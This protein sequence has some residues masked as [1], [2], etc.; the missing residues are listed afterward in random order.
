MNRWPY[1][2]KTKDH[3]KNQSN[4]LTAYDGKRI[5]LDQGPGLS[6]APSQSRS[7]A[8]TGSDKL[9]KLRTCMKHMIEKIGENSDISPEIQ[10]L[11]EDDPREKLNEQQR[12]MNLQRKMIN[13]VDKLKRQLEEK[14]T[15]FQAWKKNVKETLKKEEARH[16][17]SMEKLKK[18]LEA[19]IAEKDGVI[20]IHGDSDSD[21]DDSSKSEPP[22]PQL[23]SFMKHMQQNMEH[24]MAKTQVLEQQNQALMTQMIQMQQH[25]LPFSIG[26]MIPNAGPESGNLKDSPQHPSTP[27]V[28][29]IGDK[30][31]P[32]MIP[33]R[34]TR[35]K[36]RSS[37]YGPNGGNG[38]G[39]TTT[40][41]AEVTTMP[42]EMTT[43]PE[44]TNE[45]LEDM[46]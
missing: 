5:L 19:C 35:P 17:E 33:F 34:N 15:K 16:L 9:D 30:V 10:E 11:L 44:E 25:F 43:L 1:K 2:Q 37:P 13:K 39:G 45:K 31:E 24:S 29:R 38:P 41:V 23:E 14:E 32:S 18:D 7:S 21:M 26:S 8:S 27:V 22:H 3:E 28:R 46:G 40:E 12:A 20:P 42:E 36:E 6:Y 4:V